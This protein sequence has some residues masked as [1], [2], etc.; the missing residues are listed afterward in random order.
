LSATSLG[1]KAFFAGGYSSA[2]ASAVID[3]YT[4]Q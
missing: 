1:N 2:G 4:V 3:I